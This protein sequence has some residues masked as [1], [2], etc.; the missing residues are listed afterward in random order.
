MD[1]FYNPLDYGQ[2]LS[3]EF[4]SLPNRNCLLLTEKTKIHLHMLSH[5]SVNCNVI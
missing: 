3:L 2:S 4:Y 5:A 1:M